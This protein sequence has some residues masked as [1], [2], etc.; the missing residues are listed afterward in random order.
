MKLHTF[1]KFVSL[2]FLR[3]LFLLVWLY[4]CFRKIHNHIYKQIENRACF[5]FVST[6]ITRMREIISFTYRITNIIKEKKHV[7]AGFD[8]S[9][10]FLARIVMPK[11]R[12]YANRYRKLLAFGFFFLDW[13]FAS[14]RSYLGKLTTSNWLKTMWMIAFWMNEWMNEFFFHRIQVFQF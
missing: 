1:V 2:S 4:I 7:C 12:L 10:F 5:G 13:T 8:N 9:Y 11:Y 14:M 6:A 3:F